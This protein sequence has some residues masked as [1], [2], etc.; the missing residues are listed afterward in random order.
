[1]KP[2]L[3]RFAA[4]A[5]SGEQHLLPDRGLAQRYPSLNR[6]VG[7]W[8]HLD[9]KVQMSLQL[10]PTL[11]DQRKPEDPCSADVPAGADPRESINLGEV[12]IE[13]DSQHHFAAARG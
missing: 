10:A 1:M 7:G 5:L 3:Q 12:G 6:L 11:A 2:A 9:C 13:D 8:R 4:P